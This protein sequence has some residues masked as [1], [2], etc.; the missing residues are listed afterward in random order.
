MREYK[1]DFNHI[2]LENNVLDISSE[3][4]GIIYSLLKESYDE[5]SVDYVDG[6][7]NALEKGFYD[8]AAMFFVLNKPLINKE[9]K[10]LID[11]VTSKLKENGEIY[12]WDYKKAYGKTFIGKI[13]CSLPNNIEKEFILK[14]MN[15]MKSYDEHSILSILNKEYLILDTNVWDEI[16]FIR[17]KKKGREA[18]EDSNSGD[19][20][21]VHP[22]QPSHKI[23]KG[24]YKR[25]KLPRGDNGVLNK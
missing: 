15:I 1:L 18:H 5:I 13:I 9:R 21:K 4:Y 7:G 2:K 25:F 8:N 22:Q 3:N 19:K 16:F 6:D 14:D 24:I 10:K 17:A 23:L 12:I 20:L 11:D